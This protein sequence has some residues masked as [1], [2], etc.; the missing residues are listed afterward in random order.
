MAPIKK[1]KKIGITPDAHSQKIPLAVGYHKKEVFLLMKI[2]RGKK[3]PREHG[4][5][6]VRGHGESVFTGKPEHAHLVRI[7]PRGKKV[8]ENLAHC[9]DFK[10]FCHDD[11]M[12][13]AYVRQGTHGP[14]FAYASTEDF[15]TWVVGGTVKEVKKPG[16]LIP[17]L[18]DG[19][20]DVIYSNGG[21]IETAI[22]QNLRSWKIVFPARA[23]HWN[24]FEG[25]P[26]NIVG[27][28]AVPDGII[29]GG[30]IAL[31]YESRMK[32][33]ILIDDHL[34][35]KK[36]GD[37]HFVKIGCALFSSKNPTQLIWQTELPLM[38]ISV[39]SDGQ[40]SFIGV[41]PIHP[42]M[43]PK[44]KSKKEYTMHGVR[45]YFSDKAGKIHLFEFPL[46]HIADHKSG[47]V[48]RAKRAP[49]NPIM[50]PSQKGWEYDG[51]FNPA[52]VRLDGKVHL[53]YRAVGNDGWSRIG[54]AATTDGVRISE[55][56][57]KPVYSLH[58]H[59]I[60]DLADGEDM[61]LFSSGGSWGGCEDPKATN[62]DG[63]VYMTFVAHDGGWPMR[64]ALTSIGKK[65][66][67]NK[68][69]KWAKPQLMS[70]PNVG[71]KSVV[72][73]PEKII[74]EDGTEK[75]VVFH[76]VW[77]NIM[78]DLVPKLEFGEGKR[79]LRNL[80]SIRPRRSYWD[81]QKMS[82]GTAPI[83][84]PHG[85]LAIYSAVDRQDSSKYKIGAMLLDLKQPWKA[86]AR[87]RKPILEPDEQYENSYEGGRGKSGIVYPGG[88]VDIDGMLHIYY[89]GAD[90]VTC[91]ATV[92]V[93]ELVESLLRDRQPH[94][95]ITP[96]LL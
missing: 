83:R 24:F 36:I 1:T 22:S 85:W 65:D 58:K 28:I 43:D 4:L 90:M 13:L 77:P 2:I 54:H 80:Y 46:E 34:H 23:P 50:K 66:F 71:S 29:A 60:P 17:E 44:S 73:L 72:I 62:I 41:T 91:V 35:N 38:E 64:S 7:G 42:E 70:P 94:L 15:I 26:F 55:R 5:A 32:A 74:D 14:E 93:N 16:I 9:R 47:R 84:T 63:R 86:I 27:A 10:F 49:E 18:E 8:D 68:K 19:A 78:V 79:W 11:D 82:M 59:E 89:G 53:L 87:S 76:R 45:F 96:C 67:L 51:V 33:D 21:Q 31:F 48:T 61:S 25:L 56:G 30:G 81:S 75:Y 88:A 6:I 39:E 3:E 69:W 40:I 95:K 20:G 12:T 57:V 52:V 37:E 92:P